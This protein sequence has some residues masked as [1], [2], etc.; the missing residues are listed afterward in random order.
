MTTAS[1]N[2]LNNN[3]RNMMDYNKR[4][5][6]FESWP[7]QD[8]VNCTAEKMAATGFYCPDP[9]KEPDVV[10]CFVCRKELDGWD[11]E[12]NPVKEHTNHSRNCYFLKFKRKKNINK[13]SLEEALKIQGNMGKTL[14][15][16]NHKEK[17][18]AFEKENE[19]CKDNA[20]KLF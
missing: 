20:M 13:I 15:Q 7:F 5:E 17:I 11:P 14:K 9:E 18:K 16:Q 2:S 10:R 4:L 12:D 6:T 1:E 19:N 3:I 8:D